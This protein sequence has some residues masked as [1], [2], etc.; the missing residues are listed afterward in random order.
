MAKNTSSNP[1][2]KG[3]YNRLRKRYRH[4]WGDLPDT[5][6]VRWGGVREMEF[7]G[8]RRI[9]AMW[10]YAIWDRE[11]PLIVIN[12]ELRRQRLFKTTEATLLHEMTHL[13]FKGRDSHGPRFKER[14]RELAAAGAYNEIF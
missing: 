7:K 12:G 4:I 8:K 9:K 13:S 1:H 5:T 11:M 10:G 6:V 14:M 3:L 2:L